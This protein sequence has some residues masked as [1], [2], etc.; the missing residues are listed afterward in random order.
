MTRAF[1]E[2]T[3]GDQVGEL[4]ELDRNEL[5]IGRTSGCNIVADPKFSSVSQRHAILRKTS[6]GWTIIDVGTYGKG[7]TYGTYINDVRLVPNKQ[8]ILHPGDE[9]RLGTKLGKYLRFHGEGTAP[10]SQPLS[11][12]GRFTIDAGKRCILIDGRAVSISLTPQE[13]EFLFILWQ[14]TGSICLFREICAG[15]WPDE[16]TLTSGS[17]DADLRVR[18]NT[19]SHG[20]RR[21]LKFALDGIDIL[22]S[23]RGVGYRLRL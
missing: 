20:L 9:I 5:L 12:S 19:L 8:T 17:I 23:C 14:K 15:L 3:N 16:K 1:L 7:S 18:I 13:F 6:D 10:V 21:K 4:I 22:E 11:L 2:H